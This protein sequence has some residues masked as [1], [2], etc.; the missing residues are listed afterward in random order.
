MPIVQKTDVNVR[1]DLRAITKAIEDNAEGIRLVTF[2]T[3]KGQ[4]ARRVFNDG[5]STDGSPIGQYAEST[6]R[7]RQKAGRQTG[8][9]DLDMSSTL[10]RALVVG[11]SENR[12]VIG[13]LGQQEPTVIAVNGSLKVTGT[14]DLQ[15]D[16]N[17]I[18]QE[19]HF[20]K[21]IFAPSNEETDRAEK[22]I[23]KEIDRVVK[24]A[25]ASS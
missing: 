17:A 3:V 16:Q 7:Q 19:E 15:T 4:M 14:S 21:P 5:I 23:V 6:K 2:N 20:G 24:K 18:N 25:V 12:T 13:I 8:R 1:E 10:R 22:T 9:V 11:T